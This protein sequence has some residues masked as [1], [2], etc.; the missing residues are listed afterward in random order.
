MAVD[1]T[2][3][4]VTINAAFLQEIK[5]VN[6]DLWKLLEDTRQACSDPTNIREQAR[7]TV[8]LLENLRDQLALHFSLEEAYGYF[9]QPVHVE[10]RLSELASTLRGEHQN[11]YAMIRDLVE[12]VDEF[13]RSGQLPAKAERQSK[14]E[15]ESPG[16][17]SGSICQ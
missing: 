10:P 1:R 5:E 2:T 8:E 4:T 12:E 11:L 7:G 16:G 14:G 15:P 3:S 17:V 9:N 13:R 6:R